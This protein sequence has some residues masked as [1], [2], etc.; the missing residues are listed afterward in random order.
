MFKQNKRI[1]KHIYFFK[2]IICAKD[3][4][5][6]KKPEGKKKREENSKLIISGLSKY[7]D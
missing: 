7:K 3:N 6:R 4:I 2:I 1:L 5:G